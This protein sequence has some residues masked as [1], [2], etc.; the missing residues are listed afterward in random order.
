MSQDSKTLEWYPSPRSCK[1]L[2]DLT[3]LRFQSGVSDLD[4]CKGREKESVTGGGRGCLRISF[5]EEGSSTPDPISVGFS[6]LEKAPVTTCRV[7]WG[8]TGHG[9]SSTQESEPPPTPSTRGPKERDPCP[10]TTDISV[11]GLVVGVVGHTR[12]RP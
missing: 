8:F 1:S 7:R 10:T 11:W 5:R 3:V 9:R 2:R 4:P 12:Q 6:V